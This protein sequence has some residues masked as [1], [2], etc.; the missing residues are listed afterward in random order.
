MD[1]EDYFEETPLVSIDNHSSI[2]LCDYHQYATQHRK[3]F[4]EI[5]NKYPTP[6]I[7]DNELQ[8]HPH[9]NTNIFN[10][11]SISYMHDLLVLGG[12]KILELDDLT[13]PP[14]IHQLQYLFDLFINNYIHSVSSQGSKATFN[15]TF[16]Q[17][18]EL[19]F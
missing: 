9:D 6:N 10:E 18:K 15:T 5:L 3:Q 17:N 7:N 12:R 1:S 2:E 19:F 11:Y 13:L 8:S 14:K 16:C 4:E